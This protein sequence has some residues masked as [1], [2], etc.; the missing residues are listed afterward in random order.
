MEN[1]ITFVC[2]DNMDGI[3]TAVFDAF[4]FRNNMKEPDTD[5]ISI[6]VGQVNNFELFTEYKEVQTDL[7]KSVKT[8]GA[9]K[10]K[11]SEEAYYDLYGAAHH[12]AE[13]K[14]NT[15]LQYLFRGF[16]MGY[17]YTSQFADPYVMR[18]LEL[19]RK[20]YGESHL[21]KGFIR[22][23]Q[24]K[25]GVLFSKISPRCDVLPM[26]G[27]HFEDRLP[28]ENFVIYDDVHKSA[29]VH[30]SHSRYAVASNLSDMQGMDFDRIS[31]LADEDNEY[32]NMWKVF[33]ETIA[34]ESRTNKRCQMNM[35]PLWYRKNMTEFENN[36]RS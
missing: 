19:K 2:E 27:D 31:E 11:I 7:N 22:F 33:F 13:D 8:M 6:T 9:I 23:K 29:I 26:I 4:V 18:I 5:M 15:I 17:A 21:F 16:A 12:F 20:V 14:G 32:E 36:N 30:K 28:E 34:I 10:K 35:M 1:N 3:L 25:G 24:L